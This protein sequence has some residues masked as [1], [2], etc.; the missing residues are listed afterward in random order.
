MNEDKK[1]LDIK[2]KIMLQ[3]IEKLCDLFKMLF[4]EGS[5]LGISSLEL[6]KSK[7]VQMYNQIIEKE[8]Y[9]KYKEVEDIIIKEISKI[10]LKLDEYILNSVQHSSEIIKANADK[11][12]N[13]QNY[14]NYQNL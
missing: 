13:T 11:V 5:C 2:A 3:R 8:Q 6:I 10:E 7:Y 12:R 14:K 4:L 9:E 1:L